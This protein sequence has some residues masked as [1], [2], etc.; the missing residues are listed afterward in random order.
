[1]AKSSR[2]IRIDEDV[3][4]EFIYHDQSNPNEVKIENDNNGSQLKYLNTVDGDDSASRFLIHELGADVVEFTVTTSNGYVVINGFA[5][6]QLLLKNG[7]TYKFD[8]S[9]PSINNIA[10]FNI[11]NGNGYVSGQNYIYTP[12]TNGAY[13]YEYSNLAGVAFIGGQIEVSDRASSLFSVP[14]AETGN[15]IKTAPG[16]SGRWYAVPTSINGQ[17]ALLLSLIHI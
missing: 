15:D 3:L 4:L 11:P 17:M 6:R 9:D 16:Q 8:L 7:K 12:T 5:S 14:A 1:M 2:F 13:S 10:G